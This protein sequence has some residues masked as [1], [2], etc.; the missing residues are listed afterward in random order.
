MV[1]GVGWVGGANMT[2]LAHP[3]N[4]IF[5][6]RVPWIPLICTS[7]YFDC[8][9]DFSLTCLDFLMSVLSSSQPLVLLFLCHVPLVSDQYNY[10]TPVCLVIVQCTQLSRLTTFLLHYESEIKFQDRGNILSLVQ[11]SQMAF[12]GSIDMYLI[13]T[14]LQIASLCMALSWTQIT[15]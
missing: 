10:L 12:H 6:Y 4:G 13:W 11:I 2:C 9:L 5:I 3:Q 14:N 1:D 7:L 15:Q 8:Q